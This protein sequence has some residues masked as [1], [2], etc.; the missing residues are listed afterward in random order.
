MNSSAR[1]KER[2][3]TF[4]GWLFTAYGVLY[5]LGMG[6]VH[7]GRP[8]RHFLNHVDLYLMP[9][10][11]AS[12][13]WL[14]VLFLLAGAMFTRKRVV[15]IVTVPALVLILLTNI[16]GL[17][18]GERVPLTWV[19]PGI[20][21]QV[22]LLALLL[23]ARKEFVV[24]IR[25]ANF[26]GSIMVL[27]VG[28]IL[29]IGVGWLIVMAFP[30]D[31]PSSQ[32]LIYTIQHILSLGAMDSIREL[33]HGTIHLRATL[34]VLGALPII[35]AVV[36]LLRSQRISNTL[37]EEDEDLIRTLL[38]HYGANDSLG[39]F[40]TRRD[41]SVVFSPDGRAAITYRQE[42]G[43]ALASSDPV[44]DPDS[45]P[46]AIAQ[47]R[48]VCRRYGWSASVLGASSAGAAAYAKA[49]LKVLRVGDEAV[50]HL[51]N[52]SALRSPEVRRHVNA[53][54]KRGMSVR[55]RRHSAIS[56]AEMA[57][58]VADADRWRTGGAERGFSMALS[59]LGHPADGN[60]LLAEVLDADG[61]RV[62]MHS[63]VPWGPNGISLDLM[64]RSPDAPAGVNEFLV[65]SI[66]ENA[67]GL[68]LT[69]MSLNF[70]VFREIFE[71]GAALGAG[72]ILRLTRRILLF[73]SRFWQLES[74]YR[75]NEKYAPEWFP[76][77]VAYEETRTLGSALVAMGLAE[78]YLPRI[79]LKGLPSKVTGAYPQAH[80]VE[81]PTFDTEVIVRR[82]PEQ[83][84]V[85]TDKARALID[86]GINPW[87]VGASSPQHAAKLLEAATGASLTISGRVIRQRN[88]GSVVFL[89]VRDWSGQCQVIVDAGAPEALDF[90]RSNVDLGDLIEVS[91]SRGESRTGEPS[92]LAT[93]VRMIAKCLRPLPDK[94]HGLTDP[95][96]QVRQRHVDLAINDE[97]RR[98]LAA[99][100]AILNSLRASLLAEGYLEVETPILQPIHGGANARPFTTH[101]NAYDLDLYLRI[102]PELYLKRLCVGGVERVFELGRTFRNEGVD[103]S[104]NPEFTILE[105]YRAHADYIDMLHTIRRLIQNA[106]IAV[107]GECIVPGPDGQMVDISGE[108]PIVP[109]YDGISD[110]LAGTSVAHL[111]PITTETSVEDL[112]QVCEGLDIAYRPDWDHGEL[113]LELYEHLIEERTTTPQFNIDF[114]LS[115]SPL[116]GTHR[117]NPKLAERW[118]LVAWGVELGTAYS[119][120]TNP[121]DQRDRLTEQSVKAAGGDPEAMELDEDFLSALEFGMAPSG[122]LGMGVDR[123]VMLITGKSLRETL[124][125]P[126]VKPAGA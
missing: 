87:P 118:D 13:S 26:V 70:A 23:Y 112:Q 20:A 107:H 89:V 103:F 16:L 101:I 104:H 57:E 3:P 92:L 85:R 8:M 68:G 9:V 59:R 122:G 77:Y 10:P 45:W 111:A 6:F 35:A 110:A 62:A 69:R 30:S 41:K 63:Y 93:D 78:G 50:V 98:T 90:I 83:V 71:A 102:A 22:I 24:R 123:V 34:G 42:A 52:R 15:L 40:A 72:P 12:L 106:A 81:T 55:I 115:V 96:A 38:S 54:R 19:I 44:G 105:A 119:E 11:R 36:T 37:T 126:L 32:R 21:I 66:V 60:C 97:A 79:P 100:S 58:I 65:A 1:F 17:S 51:T 25:R 116:T 64:R 39:Y 49:G 27:V 108:W 84:R 73:A 5:L 86:E 113:V 76:R 33:G 14:V 53:S 75:A 74:L 31:V 91:G 29:A 4:F 117:H 56:E 82:V 109:I 7:I 18:S 88:F 94:Y 95:E 61:T 114:P 28:L 125:F 43:N 48:E 99:R 124:P 121:I 67:D 2:I 47:W 80:L 120:L 46:A